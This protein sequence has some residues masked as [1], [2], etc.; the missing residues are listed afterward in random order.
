M[1]MP[2]PL[3]SMRDRKELTRDKQVEI[4]MQNMTIHQLMQMAVNAKDK[5]DRQKALKA[6]QTKLLNFL[7]NVCKPMSKGQAAAISNAGNGL[8]SAG[9]STQSDAKSAGDAAK[10]GVKS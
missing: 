1:Q 5:K 7:K 3:D 2:N 9:D 8:D 4:S 10:G 6:M